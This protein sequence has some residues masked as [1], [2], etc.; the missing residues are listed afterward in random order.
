M[1]TYFVLGIKILLDVEKYFETTFVNP[2]PQVVNSA[3]TNQLRNK[4]PIITKL[5]IYFFSLKQKYPLKS[6]Y[7]IHAE[8]SVHHSQG[9]CTEKK[10]LYSVK[11][12]NTAALY[13]PSSER[14]R[15]VQNNAAP[16]LLVWG[17]GDMN[18]VNNMPAQTDTLQHTNI[19][20]AG[21]TN[22]ENIEYEL[23]CTCSQS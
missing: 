16:C 15:I 13:S 22:W 18:I 20:L 17:D 3:N 8:C 1:S 19:T 5:C 4:L 7:W 12:T 14:Y 23:S 9:K 21:P 11:A 6:R 10:I 2:P